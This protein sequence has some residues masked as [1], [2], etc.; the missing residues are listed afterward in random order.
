[1]NQLRMCWFVEFIF[2]GFFCSLFVCIVVNCM[3]EDPV[4]QRG[5]VVG[6]CDL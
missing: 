3:S 6:D 2:V 5:F 1:M 4:L